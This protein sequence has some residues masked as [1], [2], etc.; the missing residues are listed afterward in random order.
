VCSTTKVEMVRSIGADHVIDYT[1]E[2]IADGA[3]RYD[4]ILDNGGHRSLSH[5]R[6]ALTSRGTLVVVGSET[7]GRWLGGVDRLLRAPLLS[8][9]V[10]QKLIALANSENAKDLVTLSELVESGAVTPV[11]DRAYP[12]A[13]TPAAIQH[14]TEGRA[15]GKVVVTA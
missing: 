12:L 15:R 11:V 8:L 6:R 4:V 14:M 5:L 10:G 3:A 13:E 2:D 1:R 7:G 9:F